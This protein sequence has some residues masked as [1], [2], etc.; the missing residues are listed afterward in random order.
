MRSKY[1]DSVR[2]GRSGE[3]IPV[4]R[5]LYLGGFLYDGYWVFRGGK[6]AGARC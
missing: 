5:T 6:T 4:D 2:A 1:S 3:R